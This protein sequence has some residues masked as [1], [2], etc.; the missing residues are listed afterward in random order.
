MWNQIKGAD[1]WQRDTGRRWSGGGGEERS[2]HRSAAERQCS[3]QR[4]TEP[5]TGRLKPDSSVWEPSTATIRVVAT[6][7]V[8]KMCRDFHWALATLQR[9]LVCVS[10]LFKGNLLFWVQSTF[11]DAVVPPWSQWRE[12]L[13]LLSASGCVSGWITHRVLKH[14]RCSYRRSCFLMTSRSCVS[15]SVVITRFLGKHMVSLF[16]RKERI[17]LVCLNSSHTRQTK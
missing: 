17:I 6:T 11:V 8:S 9:Q 10:A 3:T 7:S 15:E 2:S 16:K 13:Y 4:P 5:H 1:W 12:K 14:S